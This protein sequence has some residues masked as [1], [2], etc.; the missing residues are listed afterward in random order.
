MPVPW[1]TTQAAF[2]VPATSP[3]IHPSIHPSTYPSTHPSIPPPT[4]QQSIWWSTQETLS[5]AYFVLDPLRGLSPCLLGAPSLGEET[6][7]QYLPFP[8]SLYQLCEEGRTG[9]KEP[10]EGDHGPASI[11]EG[12]PGEEHC[13]K[14]SFLPCPPISSDPEAPTLCQAQ[15][16][17][18]GAGTTSPEKLR[19]SVGWRERGQL[20]RGPERPA[21][22]SQGEP[23]EP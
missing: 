18:D 16:W 7:K 4:P 2:P 22:D 19:G 1:R 21:S 13:Q 11:M 9:L 10:R 14:A 15:G 6:D 23:V 8:H 20:C 3:P 5:A 12:F 17:K